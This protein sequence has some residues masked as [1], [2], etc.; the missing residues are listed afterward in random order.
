MD[1]CHRTKFAANWFIGDSRQIR[2]ILVKFVQFS[3]NGW[4][5]TSRDFLYT[6]FSRH[7]SLVRFL[8]KFSRKIA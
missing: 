3:S 4:N 8:D 1:P 2:S 7:L 5:V 6:T